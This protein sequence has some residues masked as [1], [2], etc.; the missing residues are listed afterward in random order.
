MGPDA[1]GDELRDLDEDGPPDPDTIYDT[2]NVQE[3]MLTVTSQLNDIVG[4]QLDGDD[5]I[6]DIQISEDPEGETATEYQMVVP[7]AAFIEGLR[8]I[9]VLGSPAAT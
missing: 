4:F 1:A 5:L 9:G 6:I 2:L 3:G 8:E 7:C